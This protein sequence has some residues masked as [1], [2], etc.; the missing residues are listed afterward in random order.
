MNDE[1]AVELSSSDRDVSKLSK[2]ASAKISEMPA[3]I[4]ACKNAY[5]HSVPA[6]RYIV[7]NHKAVYGPILCKWWTCKISRISKGIKRQL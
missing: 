1:N 4:N 3:C 5:V 2:G 7:H 6:E